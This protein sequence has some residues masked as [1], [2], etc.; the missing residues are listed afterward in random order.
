MLTRTVPPASSITLGPVDEHF[1]RHVLLPLP[2]RTY[3]D[4]C[5]ICLSAGSM[6]DEHV[7]PEALGGTVMTSTCRRCNNELGSSIDRP[8]VDSMFGRFSSFKLSTEASNGILGFRTLRNVRLA[9]GKDHEHAMWIDGQRNQAARELWA[10]AERFEI[11][12]RP[13]DP[14]AVALGELKSLY[15]ACCVIA[16]EILSGA[17]ADRVRG[18]LVAVRDDRNALT[19]LDIFDVAQWVRHIQP[20][21]AEVTRPESLSIHQAVVVRDGHLFPAVGWLHY[22]CESP[23]PDSA[24]LSARLEEGLRFVEQD[25]GT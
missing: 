24:A 13:P 12:A 19:D 6:T 18:D 7:P 1:D 23:F 10:G 22:V 17:T 21:K 14:K 2:E 20:Y 8:F 16:G 9:G 15:L 25:L 3:F 5:P 4:R 11:T